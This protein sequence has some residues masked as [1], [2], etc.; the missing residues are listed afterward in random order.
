MTSIAVHASPT[1]IVKAAAVKM[2]AVMAA[3]PFTDPKVREAARRFVDGYR[4]RQ[5]VTSLGHAVGM[6][7]HDVGQ[8]APTLEPGMIFTI[9]P[10][11]Q[12]PDE[13]IGVRLEDMI[14]SPAPATRTCPHPCR[15][16]SPT[17][18]RRWRSRACAGANNTRHCERRSS[19]GAT[20]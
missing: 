7:V 19:S 2:D 6:E 12:I 9:E 4:A 10:A 1:D 14:S 8:P 13:H 3:I 20:T 5:T 18:K 16:R 11:M 15:S 17:S